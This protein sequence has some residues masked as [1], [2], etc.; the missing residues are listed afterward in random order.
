MFNCRTCCTDIALIYSSCMCA[1]A[2]LSVVQP[3][4]VSEQ[5]SVVVAHSNFNSSTSLN[6]PTTPSSSSPLACDD[7][8]A[9]IQ[10]KLTTLPPRCDD[11]MVNLK[12]DQL[13]KQHS[14]GP[15]PTQQHDE[16]VYVSS[17]VTTSCRFGAICDVDVHSYGDAPDWKL[18]EEM[19]IS[20]HLRNINWGASQMVPFIYGI[21]K[22]RLRVELYD[23]GV[24]FSSIDQLVE[25]I[26]RIHD[27]LIVNISQYYEIK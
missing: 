2:T 16:R 12:M 25:D 10:I 19:I 15:L 23:D 26:G 22:M 17:N 11:F 6:D 14:S 24:Y 21:K 5:V 13:N 1:H 27:D 3:E 20:V 18:L 8:P 4:P 9:G 7:L